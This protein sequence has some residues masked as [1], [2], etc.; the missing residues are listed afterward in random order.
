M[1]RFLIKTI[2][3]YIFLFSQQA[4]GFNSS[5]YLISNTAIKLFDFDVAKNQFDKFE[6]D[7]SES[8]LHD[9]LLTFVS[10]DMLLESNIVAKKIIR[11]NEKYLAFIY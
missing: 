7:L 4:L 6:K 3:I 11:L 5:Q 9:Q 2:S 8:D 1:K 10:L